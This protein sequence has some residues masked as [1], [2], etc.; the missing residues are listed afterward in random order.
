[1]ES[2]MKRKTIIYGMVGG[3]GPVG[4]AP[5]HPSD[6]I[7]PELEKQR[8]HVKNVAVFPEQTEGQNPNSL[9]GRVK[10]GDPNQT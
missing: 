7:N 8:D 6:Y 5:Q 2:K 9:K 4:S 1:M 10:P 3:V